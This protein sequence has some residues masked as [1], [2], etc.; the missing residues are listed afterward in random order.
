MRGPNLL[1]VFLAAGC[2]HVDLTGDEH[3][4]AA[5]AD[6]AAAERAK[7]K[8]DPEQQ[9]IE[10]SHI[11][12]PFKDDPI[13]PPRFYNPS[14]AYLSMADQRMASAFKHLDAARRLEHF[15]DVACS[16]ISEAERTSC[17]LI[18]PHVAQI[19]EGSRGVVLHLKSAE[20]ARTL[21][22]QMR[23][24]LAFA[25]ANDFDRTPCPLYV[26]GVAITL[27]GPTQIEVASP[28]PNVAREVREEARRMFGELVARFEHP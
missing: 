25:K 14:Q 24:H 18:A 27:I 16:G 11:T 15:E 22:I 2:A 1:V 5:A 8:F 26:K 19:E 4:D 7:A 6:I 21:S 17:P 10:S 12:A 28:D 3:R 23:C 20:R 13:A 9:R